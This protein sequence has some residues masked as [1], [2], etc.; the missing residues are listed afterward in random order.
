[1][2]EPARDRAQELSDLAA[3]EAIRQAVGIVTA[4]AVTAGIVYVMGH[5]YLGEQLASR[6][7]AWW[8]H[9]RDPDRIPTARAVAELQ[10]DISRYEHEQAARPR[11]ERPRGLYESGP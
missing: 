4:V 3:Q 8:Q 7:R 11:P 2:A 6:A 10:R 9:K 5:R 1:M